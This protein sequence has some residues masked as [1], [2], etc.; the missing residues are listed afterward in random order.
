M[1]LQ[2]ITCQQPMQPGKKTS[3]H[4]LLCFLET[5]LK[6]YLNF[7]SMTPLVLGTINSW[8]HLHHSCNLLDCNIWTN[9]FRSFCLKT[10][11]AILP[12]VVVNY[13]SFHRC[14]VCIAMKS[15]LPTVPSCR[16]EFMLKVK[17]CLRNNFVPP[18]RRFS[19]LYAAP[20]QLAKLYRCSRGC[21]TSNLDKVIT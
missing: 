19:D 17:M 4:E 1:E 8:I 11:F 5:N 3:F 7:L 9:H 16:K 10:T 15:I 18:G 6:P 21:L 14:D 12:L 20:Q 2:Q 13:P